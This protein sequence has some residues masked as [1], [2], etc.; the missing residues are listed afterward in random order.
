MSFA[1]G[2][3]T[4]TPRQG[5][6][7][8][9]GLGLNDDIVCY[10]QMGLFSSPKL[11]YTLKH[12]GFRSV[13]VLDGGL[14][15]WIAQG[16]K[17][18]RD[19][20]PD[21][22][23]LHAESPSAEAPSAAIDATAA[24]FDQWRFKDVEAWL[25]ESGAQKLQVLDARSKARFDGVGA[26]P[27]PGVRSG[28]M[29]ESKSLPF[30]GMLAPSETFASTSENLPGGV[31]RGATLRPVDELRKACEGVDLTSPIAV[32]CGS[33]LTAAIVLLALHE[34]EVPKTYLYDGA[35]LEYEASGKP[36]LG[37]A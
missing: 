29:P 3:A 24:A 18:D 15:A 7:Q 20:L 14:P 22:E 36:I 8:K 16:G 23:P 34:L 25:Q 5:C 1:P 19:V 9:L 30:F 11:W 17:V 4:A 6:A 12:F 37:E 31:F 32:T 10:D 35:W 2:P 28:H 26:E 27:R 33:G 21:A 13:A